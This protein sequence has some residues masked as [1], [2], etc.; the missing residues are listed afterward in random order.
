[1]VTIR[2]A[3]EI[4]PR[5]GSR[6]QPVI[7]RVDVASTY[8]VM[9]S[10]ML[11]MLGITPEWTSVFDY[12]DGSSEEFPLAE[13]RLRFNNQD[14]TVVCVFGKPDSQPLLGAH[15]LLAFGLAVDPDGGALLPAQL[16]LT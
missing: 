14:R 5:D 15:T 1:M 9:P 7:A 10:P 12:A 6:L 13:T 4:G 8:A 2:Q 11:N 3:V 16:N